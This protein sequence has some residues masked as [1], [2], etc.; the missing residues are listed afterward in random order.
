MNMLPA[1]LAALIGS[2]AAT[3]TAAQMARPA[4]TVALNAQPANLDPA[5]TP[6]AANFRVSYSIF[7]TLIRRDFLAEIRDPAKGLSL[8]PG[9]ATQWRRLDERTLELRLQRGRALSQRRRDER[10]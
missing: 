10:R 3:P 6:F 9:L 4:L 7:D 8:I 5:E 2:I 1:A